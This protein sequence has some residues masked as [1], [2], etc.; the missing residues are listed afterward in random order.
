MS[1]PM[2]Y[3]L[4]EVREGYY[5]P[6]MIKKAWA[7]ELTILGQI[8][9]I[10]MRHGIRYFAD[11]GTMLGTVRHAGFVPWDDDLD[12]CM[13]R[14]DYERFCEVALSELPDGYFLENFHTDPSVDLFLGRITSRRHICFDEDY[15]KS[16]H[17]FPYRTGVDIFVLDYLPGDTKQ[18]QK[19]RETCL[20]LIAIADALYASHDEKQTASDKP[21]GLKPEEENL[22]RE[23]ERM[24]HARIDRRQHLRQQIY[25]LV[26]KEFAKVS[27]AEANE[28]VQMFPWGLKGIK[29]VPKE[30]YSET[31]RLPFECVS[32]PVPAAYDLMLTARYGDYMHVIK[33]VA[34]HDY[35]YFEG[36]RKEFEKEQKVSVPSFFD[37]VWK[38][39]KALRAPKDEEVM[40]RKDRSAFLLE[41]PE[42]RIVVFL[43]FKGSYW[44]SMRPVYEEECARIDTEV[45]VI[46]IP[47]YYKHLGRPFGSEVLD[48]EEYPEDLPGYDHREI[49]LELLHP[50][51][52]YIQNPYDAYHAGI[53]VLEE[54]Y[55]AHLRSC[56]DCLVYVPYFTVSDFEK[57]QVCE[58]FCLTYYCLVPGVA[59]ADAVL[60]SSEKIRERFIE[61]WEEFSGSGSLI[62]EKLKICAPIKTEE[63]NGK[64]KVLYRNTIG[65]L[66]RYGMKAIEKTRQVLAIFNENRDKVDLLWAPQ[67]ELA[68]YLP[69]LPQDISEA[70]EALVADYKEKNRG[71]YDEEISDARAV[72]ECDAY[73]GDAHAIAMQFLYAKKP[74]MIG[75]VQMIGRSDE[76]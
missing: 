62:A 7:A 26:E 11:W 66:S 25:A 54:H 12:I 4:D 68:G 41:D 49:D 65:S 5:V 61:K 47:Y 42:K 31:V 76:S 1:I 59:Y 43:P 15:L 9:E 51:V 6:A 40:G 71:A 73:Y 69:R 23:A 75:N 57:E 18:A 27:E 32:M 45:F 3:L 64:K 13:L 38:D 21:I 17:D 34:G 44:E 70:Y 28:V 29:A 19:E 56:T 33:N 10:C 52:I 72:E 8:D 50:D 58:D 22:V 35:P 53:T 30:Y 48:Y 24:C 74:V 39:T 14:R 67:K 46:P 55:A 20:K 36:Q 16:F 37:P 63:Q 2:E 60:L